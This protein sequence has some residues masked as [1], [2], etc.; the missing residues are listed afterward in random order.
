MGDLEAPNNWEIYN[1]LYI[2]DLNFG[3]VTV[4]EVVWVSR[5]LI[6]KYGLQ[7]EY[8]DDDYELNDEALIKQAECAML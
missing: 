2:A 5:S 4:D 3:Y 1:L 7:D 8:F 6:E